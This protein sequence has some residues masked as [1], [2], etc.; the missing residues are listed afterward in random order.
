MPELEATTVIIVGLKSSLKKSKQN[1][2]REGHRMPYV[3][4][5]R[6]RFG[7]LFWTSSALR[8]AGTVD[9]DI[10]M[11]IDEASMVVDEMNMN[12]EQR[13]RRTRDSHQPRGQNR[14]R[15]TM[16]MVGTEQVTFDEIPVHSLTAL[17]QCREVLR[18]C[19]WH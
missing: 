2:V 3:A 11:P 18:I 10:V 15:T 16:H 17:V 6:L 8:L 9:D 5:Y 14:Y 7:T 19:V 13:T 4:V 12:M 1:L